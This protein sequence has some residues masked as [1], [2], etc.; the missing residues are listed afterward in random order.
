MQTLGYQRQL[1]IVNRLAVLDKIKPWLEI[2]WKEC[3]L[4]QA[5]CFE[6]AL[7][8]YEA[9]ANI[10]MYA[11]KKPD[12]Y[13]VQTDEC[14]H[15]IDIILMLHP[16]AIEISIRDNGYDFDPL[17]IPEKQIADTI[18]GASLS[19]RGIPLMRGLS[20]KLTYRRANGYNYLSI[21]R[22]LGQCRRSP[23]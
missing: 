11:Y 3:E 15:N 8:V 5:L 12:G 17:A 13:S 10:V 6:M 18:S 2:A 9:V 23:K 20:D 19:G 16:E 21:F 14:E 1:T 22:E 7:C 4:P